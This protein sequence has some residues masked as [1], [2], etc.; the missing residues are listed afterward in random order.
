MA[1]AQGDY[2]ELKSGTRYNSIIRVVNDAHQI[3]ITDL[4]GKIWPIDHDFIARVHLGDTIRGL[5]GWTSYTAKYG[6]AAEIVDEVYMQPTINLH[7]ELLAN[8]GD[9]LK[10]AGEW[11]ITGTILLLGGIVTSALS[12]P[13]KTPS[14]AYA[15]A[16]V[17]GL[18]VVLY[19]PTFVYVQ[20][21]ARMR[22]L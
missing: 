18:G 22:Q 7:S 6:N 10:R 9:Y 2:I 11:G 15:G 20:K 21:A 12:V 17:S 1:K 5:S 19:I 4:S 16:A 8:T 14:M 3:R 13:L